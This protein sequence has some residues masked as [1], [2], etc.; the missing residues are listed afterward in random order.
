MTGGPIALEEARAAILAGLEPLAAEE[1]PLVAALG[2]RLAADAVAAEPMQPFDNSA[3]DGFAVRAADTAGAAP[4]APATL[5]LVGE[6]RA[7]HPAQ[8]TV[9]AAEAIAIST[10]AVLPA[11]ADAVVRV[12]D[13]RLEGETVLVE[14]EVATGR[15]VR[16][17]GEDF[18][19]G[20]V[21]LPRGAAIGAAELGVLAAI[22]ADPVPCVRRPR[23]AVLTSGD[24][25]TPLG[26]PLAPGAIR[27]S[28]GYAVP[29]LARLAGAEV[30]SVG[31]APDEPAA[32]EEA[33][34]A[35][36][37]ADVAIVCGGVSV[38]AHDHVKGALERLGVV[39]AFWRVALRPGGP[40]WFG[41]RE[42]TLVF[43]LPGNPVSVVVTF[44]LL[45]RPA[46]LALGGGDPAG[47]RVH[48]RLAADVERPPG[49][50][51]AARCRLELTDGGWL[52]HP[53]PR[54]G[55][56]VL[57]S[58]VGADGLALVP[59]EGPGGNAGETVE[60]E[61]LDGAGALP[62]GASIGS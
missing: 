57:T 31:W 62:D 47:R 26:E 19:A 59:A 14:A 28:N 54:Q 29:A 61:L 15:N 24:E 7:G 2:R 9:G 33:V 39:E 27:D 32:T 3:M 46:L 5:R 52:A 49:R 48:A 34:A 60:V 30:V 13:T 44:L 58:L 37:S 18:A 35:A 38:G 10:G 1:V 55:S 41:R 17:A 16:R 53:F 6:S 23:V 20:E 43:G 51:H 8:A 36:L 42:G 56:H 25:L 11:G 21:V 50:A 45:A 22:G 12:E 4:G 40:T